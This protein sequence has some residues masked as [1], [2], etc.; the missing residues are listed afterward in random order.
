MTLSELR[1]LVSY[2]LD[3]LAFGYF[4]TIQVDLWLNNATRE[5]QRLML[6]KGQMYY[7]KTVQTT[8]V[9]NQYDYVLP[10]DFLRLHRLEIVV[11]GT[12]PNESISPVAP[13]TLNQKDLVS[14]NYGTPSSYYIKKNRLTLLPAPDTALTL[15]LYYS[16]LVTNMTLTTDTPDVPEAYHELIG[17]LAVIDGFMKDGRSP[18]DYLVAKRMT[19]MESIKLDT[20]ERLQD[21]PRGIVQT[22]F[23]SSDQGFWY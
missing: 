8:M 12:P 23:S 10:E 5:V 9:V 22:E 4:T 3:D 21:A 15:R 18:N 16:Y 17:V 1:S 19:L 13:I 6:D 20:S 11:S 7:L 14:G 2:T